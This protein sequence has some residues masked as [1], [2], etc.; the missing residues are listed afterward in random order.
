MDGATPETGTGISPAETALDLAFVPVADCYVD[1]RY[2][3][4]PSDGSRARLKKITAGFDWTRFGALTVARQGGRYAVIDG[5]HRLEAARAI[6]AAT[7]PPVVVAADLQGQARSFVG[8][9]AVR[10]GVASIDKFRARVA[11]G[12]AHAVAV[13]QLLSKIGISTDVAAGCRLAPNETRAV[14]QLEKIAA[15]P[16]LAHLGTVLRMLRDAQPEQPNLLT[17]FAIVA[18]SQAL[19]RATTRR[20]GPDRLA[21]TLAEI[22]FETL[23]DEAYQLV[24]LTG[25]TLTGRGADLLMQRY[26]KG[27]RKSPPGG[28]RP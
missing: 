3:R 15:G 4:K 13:A 2:Q 10:T 14:A 8:I 5:Q 20:Q 16:G 7:V 26:D 22:D 12:D 21:D 11:S 24:K 17:A 25:G 19:S 9:N 1:P 28:D 6:G 27:L 18:T 23:R